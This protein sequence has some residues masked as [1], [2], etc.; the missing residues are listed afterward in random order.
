MN[1][2][3]TIHVIIVVL[4]LIFTVYT[5]YVQFSNPELTQTQVFLKVIGVN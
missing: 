1:R 3:E 5:L 2:N 4:M